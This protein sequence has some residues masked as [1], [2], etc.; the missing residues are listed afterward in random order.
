MT[1]YTSAINLA[2]RLIIKKGRTVT[3]RRFDETPGAQPW[4]PPTVVNDDHSIKAV[5]LGKMKQDRDGTLIQSDEELVLVAAKDLT[6]VPTTD[7]V[8]VDGS[9][10]LKIATADDLKPGDENVMYT[11]GV[12]E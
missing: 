2:S 8:I 3:L 6:I 11:L 9:T 12:I 5:F 1:E 4:D 7:D 10:I